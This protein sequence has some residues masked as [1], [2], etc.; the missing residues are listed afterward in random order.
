MEFLYV[1]GDIKARGYVAYI[2]FF[3]RYT[4]VR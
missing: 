1:L 3:E 2:L 4:F